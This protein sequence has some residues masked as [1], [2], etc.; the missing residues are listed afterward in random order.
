MSERTRAGM[1]TMH[2]ET[3]LMMFFGDKAYQTA[4]QHTAP[5]HRRDWLRKVLRVVMQSVD[6]IETTTRHKQALM[7]KAE[8]ASE[9]IGATDNPSWEFVYDL[10][11]LIGSLLGYYSIKAKRPHT[12]TYWQTEEQA[13]TSAILDGSE[14]ESAFRSERDDAVT[15][16]SG[17]VRQLK[18]RGMSDFK[19]ALVMN[20]TEY[21]IKK[22]LREAR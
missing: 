9:A 13:F 8:S 11:G 18:E 20:T 3:M 21:D 6:K 19:I 5:K 4:G 12:P 14:T 10:I 1:E 7:S 16:R 2:F 15:V 22:H 17:V